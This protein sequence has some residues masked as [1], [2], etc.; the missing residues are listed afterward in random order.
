MSA[1]DWTIAASFIH[2]NYNAPCSQFLLPCSG[3]PELSILVVVT[4]SANCRERHFANP[5][6]IC[7]FTANWTGRT[8][9]KITYLCNFTASLSDADRSGS[10]DFWHTNEKL[11][12]FGIPKS[13][14]QTS[15]DS[16][17]NKLTQPW[18]AVTS[19]LLLSFYYHEGKPRALSNFR[20]ETAAL[21]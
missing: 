2:A 17:S 20:A 16:Q 19:V 8:N 12:C 6:W 4:W 13:Q 7:G 21:W 1:E 15:L 10:L 9:S 14:V 3:R 5:P 11:V 18:G